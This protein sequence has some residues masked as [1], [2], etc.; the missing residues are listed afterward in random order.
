MNNQEYIVQGFVIKT[1]DYKEYDA[2]ITCLTS[3]GII[4]FIAKGVNKL[5]SK[6]R[7]SCT[8]YS[9]SEFTL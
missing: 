1:V 6:N 8:L 2:I 3:D 4:S 9:F 5:T 7:V